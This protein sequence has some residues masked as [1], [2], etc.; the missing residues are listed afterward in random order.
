MKWYLFILPYLLCFALITWGASQVQFFLAMSQFDCITPKKWNYGS[1]PK[2]EGFL[3]K[4]G[5]PCLWPS[6]MGERRTTF[7]KACMERWVSTVQVESDQWTVHSPHQTQLAKNIPFLSPAPPHSTHKA[8]REAPS[9]HDTT[10]HWLHGNS[11]PK[12]GCHYFWPLRIAFPME[13]DKFPFYTK[14]LNPIVDFWS[15]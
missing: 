14:I 10:S 1:S 3:L 12:I 4:Y 8:K 11:I 7:A 15:L 6:Y 2:I 9:L 13:G 5:V